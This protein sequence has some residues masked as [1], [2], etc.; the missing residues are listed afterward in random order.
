MQKVGVAP[1]IGNDQ[2]CSWLYAGNPVDLA[3]LTNVSDNPTSADNQQERSV[4][5]RQVV[6]L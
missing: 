3:V 2:E 4:S 6:D 1:L 5:R